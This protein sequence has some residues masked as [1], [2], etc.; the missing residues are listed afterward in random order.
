VTESSRHPCS[1]FEKGQR[2][3][4]RKG[5]F[6]VYTSYPSDK[7]EFL[8]SARGRMT[9]S[10]VVSHFNT[11]RKPEAAVATEPLQQLNLASNVAGMGVLPADASLVDSRGLLVGRRSFWVANRDTS[12]LSMF[13]RDV[14]GRRPVKPPRNVALP[15]NADGS[16]VQPTGLQFN[17]CNTV[18]GS[19]LVGPGGAP[20]R[21]LFVSLSGA[22]G[23][24]TRD[25]T[26]FLAV[27]GVA[28]PTNAYTGA[29]LI[30]GL[31][32]AANFARSRVDVYNGQ[33]A[34]QGSFTDGALS[35]AGY[36][37]FNVVG[38]PDGASLLVSFA[39]P[40]D[41]GLFDISG[42]GNGFLDVVTNPAGAGGLP[43]VTRLANRGALNSPW[44]M[45]FGRTLNVVL[46]GNHGDGG[47]NAFSL[48]PTQ[49]DTPDGDPVLNCRGQ[50][51]SVDG[52]WGLA[53]SARGAEQE[54]KEE[55]L[56]DAAPP[57]KPQ[58]CGGRGVFPS[59]FLF[60]AGPDG[61]A[62]GLVGTL[63]SCVAAVGTA[64]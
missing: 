44:A 2:S 15:A 22:L 33:W 42:A 26:A 52:L 18:P 35:V 12:T 39:K 34:L 53:S 6:A 37:P 7:P 38:M 58:D 63:S 20:V 61:G 4:I 55:D 47:V 46:V 17:R 29:A 60:S 64:S 9:T 40:G 43:V 51:V 59:S 62:Q 32:Y 54:A 19:F 27:Q 10:A 28:K 11:C 45:V 16:P 57:P 24:V 50:P 23:G 31:L 49:K 14:V 21:V 30:G 25:G 48:D 56:R 41:G 13:S 1:S 5:A 3:V 36:A 8:Q